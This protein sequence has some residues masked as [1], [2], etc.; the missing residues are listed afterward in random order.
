[1]K[2]TLL[3][4]SDQAIIVDVLIESSN[5]CESLTTLAWVSELIDK[6]KAL[7]TEKCAI[8]DNELNSILESYFRSKKIPN[9]RIDDVKLQINGNFLNT[10]LNK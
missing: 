8:N 5:K 10:T 6:V 9:F 1:M 4:I 2:N 7:E 3:N